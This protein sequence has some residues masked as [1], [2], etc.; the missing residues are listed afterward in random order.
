MAISQ[1]LSGTQ[2]VSV[3]MTLEGGIKKHKAVRVGWW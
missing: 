2:E 3:M 1:R